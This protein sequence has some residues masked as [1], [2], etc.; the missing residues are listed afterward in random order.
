VLLGLASDLIDDVAEA[1]LA[2]RL[3][4]L[5]DRGVIALAGSGLPVQPDQDYSGGLR[6]PGTGARRVGLTCCRIRLESQ[7]G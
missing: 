5:A 3:A 7:P 4:E 2:L 6:G 1:R